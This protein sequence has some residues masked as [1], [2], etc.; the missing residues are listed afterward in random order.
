MYFRLIRRLFVTLKMGSR[1][2]LTFSAERSYMIYGGQFSIL[3]HKI[4]ILFEIFHKNLVIS[5]KTYHFQPIGSHFQKRA[6][7]VFSKKCQPGNCV[8]FL[9]RNPFH[10]FSDGTH[11]NP[12]LTFTPIFKGSP[13]S[14]YDS[15]DCLLGLFV[16]V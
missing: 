15:G 13:M 1:S 9:T 3:V 14:F 4:S 6:G 12:C 7:R 11:K 2:F 8:F 10:N 16:K 5:L